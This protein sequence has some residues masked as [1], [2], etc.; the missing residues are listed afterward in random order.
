MIK[1]GWG[2]KTRHRTFQYVPRYYDPAR[3]AMEDR[4]KRYSDDKGNLKAEHDSAYYIERLKAG[5]RM[6][7]GM[8]TVDGS[9]AIRQSN[10][11]VVLIVLVLV[12]LT[13]TLI[14]MHK[15]GDILSYFT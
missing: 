13:Y 14:N 15:I 3:E 10:K 1:I 4:K 9:A 6:K 8:Y 2:G 5:L 12:I 7:S 11:R